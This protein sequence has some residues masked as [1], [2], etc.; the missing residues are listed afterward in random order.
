MPAFNPTRASEATMADVVVDATQVVLTDNED[1]KFGASTDAHM[2]YDTSDANANL[3]M[4]QLPEGAGANVPVFLLCCAAGTDP[5]GTDLGLFNGIT[6]TTLAVLDADNDSYLAIDFSADDSPRIRAGGSATYWTSST[7]VYVAAFSSLTQGSGIALSS[8]QTGALRS[9][10]DDAGASIGSSVRNILGRT[11]L[12]VDQSGGSIRSVMGQLKL[13]TGV[14]VTTGIYTGVQGYVELAGTH[15][16]QTGAT[17]SCID[18]SLEITTSLTVDSGGEACGIHVETTGAGTITNNGTCAAILIDKASGAASWPVGINLVS[19]TCTTGIAIGTCTDGITIGTCTDGITI[20]GATGYALDVQTSGQV[21]LGVQGTGIPTATATPFAVEIHA[22]TGETELTAGDTGLTCGI[23]CRYEVSVDQTKQISFEAID[24]RLRPKKD[25]ADGNHCGINGTIEASESGTVLSGTATTVRSGGFFSLD[26]DANV[27]ITS[28]WLCGVTIDS[29]VHGDVS[30][31]SCTFCGLRIKT[32]SGKEVW[33]H[34]IYLDDDSAATGITLGTTTTYGIDVGSS[35]TG[36]A[37]TGT[38]TG[39]VID[40]SNAT[41]DPTGSNGPCFI[42]AGTY[43]S[44]IDYGADNH[45]SG[46][47]RLYST[48]AGDNTSYDRGLFVCTKTTGA[49]GAF[50]V[51][52]L[53]EANNTGTG[54][55][56]LQAAQFIAHLG[57]DNSAS[58]LATLGGDSTAGMY[59]AWLKITAGGSCVCDSGSRCAPAWIDNQMSGTISGEEYGIFA[60]T[61][62]SRPDAFIGFETT[63]SGYDQLLYFDETFNAGAGTCVTGDA[64]PATQDARIKVYYNGTQYYLPLYR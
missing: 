6:Q 36:I 64:V 49:K 41:I 13:A 25:L 52:G 35:A 5:I 17:F 46:M 55:K 7:P 61:G 39:N 37:F 53:A 33:E 15:V 34:G 2:T 60:T 12:T 43:A 45:Q 21:R 63:S 48:C 8:T 23:R 42:R 32:S 28:G 44:P 38:Y 20:T 22:E 54:P 24:A 30:M 58:H 29:S 10:A 31:A 59:G 57:A 26:F 18:A 51:A 11:L 16:A 4:C 50:P 9:Y 14:D 3:L 56:K 40:F 27:S 62:A 19:S 47:I 1:L